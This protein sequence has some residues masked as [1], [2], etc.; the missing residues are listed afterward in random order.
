MNQFDFLNLI[1]EPLLFKLSVDLVN[2]KD[3]DDTDD[4]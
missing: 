2:A 1:R 3:T 4:N